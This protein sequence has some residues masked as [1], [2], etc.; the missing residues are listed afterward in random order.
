[1]YF[2][3]ST[4]IKSH[5]NNML[6]YIKLLQGGSDRHHGL[7]KR[8]VAKSLQCRTVGEVS[9]LVLNHGHSCLSGTRTGPDSHGIDRQLHYPSVDF[10]GE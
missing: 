9:G 8:V 6:K 4:I 1:M 5:S 3:Q 2:K 7:H 10:L